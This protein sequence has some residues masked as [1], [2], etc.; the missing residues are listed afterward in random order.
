MNRVYQEMAEE[1]IGKK[2]AS[3]RKNDKRAEYSAGLPFDQAPARRPGTIILEYDIGEDVLYRYYTVRYP[4]GKKYK[5]LGIYKFR[6]CNKGTLF[7]QLQDWNAFEKSFC[8]GACASMEVRL[9]EG[10][11]REYRW[12][13]AVFS[14]FYNKKKLEKVICYLE[15]IEDKSFR[16]FM[17]GLVRQ[18]RNTTNAVIGTCDDLLADEISG[19]TACKL[20]LIRDAGIGLNRT[21]EDI[22]KCADDP[23]G[24]PQSISREYQLS[25]FLTDVIHLMTVQ[26]KKRNIKLFL[27]LKENVPEY[28][29][30]DDFRISQILINMISN[31]ARL[32]SGGVMVLEAGGHGA[33]EERYCLELSVRVSG[34]CAGE[35]AFAEAMGDSGVFLSRRLARLM[36]GNLTAERERGKDV[37]FHITLVQT[38]RSRAS[39]VQKVDR[40]VNV[41]VLERDFPVSEQIAGILS[42]LQ[43]RYAVS[44]GLEAGRHAEEYTHVLMRTEHLP[45][46]REELET[47]FEGE[48]LILLSESDETKAVCPAGCRRIPASLM[49]LY[50][51]HILNSCIIPAPSEVSEVRCIPDTYM[52]QR[53]MEDKKKVRQGKGKTEY[54]GLALLERLQEACFSMEYDYA[55]EIIVKMLRFAYPE[56]IK[57][58]LNAMRE[59]CE[60]FDYD[61]LDRLVSELA[62]ND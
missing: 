17:G 59:C 58:R 18:I 10:W 13:R 7:I 4:G 42:R 55:E 27:A 12:Y 54:P 41:L 3:V 46:V 19:D 60:K 37:S 8:E 32:A 34:I 57:E 45:E 35:E 21:A 11:A 14:S 2:L 1:A 61:L 5:K 33:G 31:A 30:G 28:L 29:Y 52:K 47:C 48:Q 15:N 39:A 53:H 25:S 51:P 44:S 43:V 20:K 23:S 9:R 40:R 24:E 38:M 49:C 56:E 62:D 6:E 26:L 36:G 16:I 22:F 50:L